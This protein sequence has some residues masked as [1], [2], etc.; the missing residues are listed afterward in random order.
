MSSSLFSFMK[1]VIKSGGEVLGALKDRAGL[2]LEIRKVNGLIRELDLKREALEKEILGK[3]REKAKSGTLADKDL[4]D[5]CRQIDQA[6]KDTL[7]HQEQIKALRAEHEKRKAEEKAQKDALLDGAESGERTSD[8]EIAAPQPAAPPPAESDLGIDTG[9]LEGISGAPSASKPD[10]KRTVH[11]NPMDPRTWQE[12]GES[13][14]ASGNAGDA[15]EA[16]RKAYSLDPNIAGVGETLSRMLCEEGDKMLSFE[17]LSEASAFFRKSLAYDPANERALQALESMLPGTVSP[18]REGK[19]RAIFDQA[20]KLVQENSLEKAVSLYASAAAENP[21]F[22]QALNLRGI[23]L[24]RLGK[25]AEAV[26]AHRLALETDPQYVHAWRY[27]GLRLWETGKIRQSAAAMKRAT[28]LAPN[29][30]HTWYCLGIAYRDLN[31]IADAEPA[32]LKAL[33]LDPA[34]IDAW[35]DLGTLRLKANRAREA[36]EAFSRGLKVKQDSADCWDGLAHATHQLG[37][38]DLALQA[39]LKATAI[40]PGRA[41]SWEFL[42]AL[43]EETGEKEKSREALSKAFALRKN[44]QK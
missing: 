31:M 33:E 18:E 15:F 13:L 24:G 2:E 22:T 30:A 11:E 35:Y 14:L 39:A 42:G 23:V 17:K 21:R 20:Q 10:L 26:E 38:K 44:T 12:M 34:K 37:R 25:P 5:L 3:A 27:L 4:A 32:F 40:D 41:E 1:G 7:Q 43:Y 9:L 19:A 29:D 36:N 6:E 16:F 8:S 28:D